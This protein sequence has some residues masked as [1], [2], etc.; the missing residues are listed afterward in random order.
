MFKLAHIGTVW[1]DPAR[2]RFPPI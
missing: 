1:G 2:R